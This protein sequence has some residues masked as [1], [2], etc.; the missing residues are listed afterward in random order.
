M[1]N[2]LIRPII[3]VGN[4]SGVI[5]PKEWR[6]GKVKVKLVEEPINI[7]KD[8]LEILDKYLEYILGIYIIGSYARNE[9][10]PDSD[11]DILVLTSK[12]NKRILKGK[13]EIILLSKE[14][15]EKDLLDNAIPLIPWIK[16]SKTLINN[17]LIEKYKN[18]QLSYKNIK[19]HID[20]NKTAMNVI[21]EDIKLS[22]EF[23]E[24][25][26]MNTSIYS[27]ILRLRTIYIIECIKKNQKWSNKEFINLIKEI[28]GSINPYKIY[29]EIKNKKK[30]KLKISINETRKLMEYINKKNKEIEKW[31]KEKED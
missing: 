6:G 16:E 1:K 31:T 10:K 3:R 25:S 11:I 4:S 8:L 30:S 18:S 21:K 29:K 14:N 23:P 26:I 7:K 13:Y 20:T 22:E 19:W 5:L 12:I 17:S 9:Q 28:S 15:L 24:I 27:L 2:E